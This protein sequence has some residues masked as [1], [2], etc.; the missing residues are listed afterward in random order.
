MKIK[1]K[2]INPG[3][4]ENGLFNFI[5]ATVAVDIPTKAQLQH[6]M[7][8][9]VK[10]LYLCLAATFVHPTDQFNKKVGCARAESYAL[11][12]ESK[13]CLLTKVEP[14]EERWVYHFTSIIPDSR[15]NF[16]KKFLMVEF[17][18][19]LKQGSEFTRLEYVTFR[20]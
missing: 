6:M 13:Y 2:H 9:Q 5:R 20:E 8:N 18:V 14:N 15:F 16:E 1:V 3:Q 10:H 17:G 7:T 19:S 12:E 4:D 11:S